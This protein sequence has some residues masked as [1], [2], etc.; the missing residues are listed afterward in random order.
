MLRLSL[1]LLAAAAALALLPG[2]A[3]AAAPCG[4]PDVQP[5]W[6]DYAE[7]TVSFRN[8]IFGRHDVIAATS[9]NFV[10]PDLRRHGA[11]TVFWEMRLGAQ[12][13]STVA[14]R[15]PAAIDQVAQDLFAKAGASSACPTPWIALN[16]LQGAGTTT[17]WSASNA[18]YRANVLALVQ[19]LAARGARPFLL[20]S[21]R[22]YTGGD[23]TDWWRRVAL[24]A[25][26]VPEVY[27]NANVITR[28]GPLVGGRRVRAAFRRA[29]GD[30]TEI[31]IP[32]AR[33]GL[34]LGFQSG[35]GLGGREGLAPASSW[36]EYVK[37]Q[38]LAARAVA[39]E[40]GIGSVWSWGWG[41][42][43]QAGIDPDKPAAACVYLWTRDPGLCDGPAAAGPDFDPSRSEGQLDL[44]E[45]V[46]CTVGDA[47][48]TNGE[49]T[50]LA[51][52]T[53]DR[54][55]ARTILFA[56]LAEGGVVTI[57][58]ADVL[59]AEKTIIFQQF[60]G[61]R[62][63][64]L[65]AL[66]R[67]HVTLGVARAAI[68]DELRRG[69]VGPTL[70][71][72]APSMDDVADFYRTYPGVYVR[73]VQ[74]TP[75]PPWLGRRPQ[76]LAL[77]S[78]APAQV[79]GI[80]EGRLAQVRTAAGVYAVRALSAKMPLGSFPLADVR[81]A[82]AATLR[83]HARD[84][85]YDAWSIARQTAA[86]RRTT[87]VRDQLPEVASIPLTDFVPYLLLD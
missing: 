16:E 37:L 23:A 28:L 45:G 8:E 40:L 43:S 70:A 4:L 7:G 1:I 34:V 47:A 46:Q 81:Q 79:F 78:L 25:D 87:C 51:A 57:P 26:I 5:A 67:S 33:L 29:I 55:V 50:E 60:R 21:T 42:V 86:Q 17:P 52:A 65:A 10:A 32:P 38:A 62:A 9:G 84:A 53:G 20:V 27:F 68:A 58:G 48:I 12:V 39:R 3:A 59:A 77:A 11:H 49:V 13:G 61:S 41:T 80:R 31:G 63:A 76:G 15:D 64:Y 14:P 54:E 83:G 82:I 19:G 56:R 85:A 74:A 66:A 35:P 2:P 44:P 6:V 36:F 22:P 72:P 18:Q 69:E 30:F 71:A 24:A 75:A 73:P